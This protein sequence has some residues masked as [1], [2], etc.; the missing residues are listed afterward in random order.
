MPLSL[1]WEVP[2][3]NPRRDFI[4]RFHLFRTSAWYPRVLKVCPS[5]ITR[6]PERLWIQESVMIT[7]DFNFVDTDFYLE[8]MVNDPVKYLYA[9]SDPVATLKDAG[10]VLHP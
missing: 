7:K 6:I 10:P 9:S 1:L 2:R 3:Q 4:L 8:Y 5:V